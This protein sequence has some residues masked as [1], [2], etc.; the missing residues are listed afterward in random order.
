M[1]NQNIIF[2]SVGVAEMTETEAPIPAAGEV[3]VRSVRDTISTGTERA[4]LMGDPNVSIYSN[5][6]V[7]IYPRSAGYSIAGV[8][9]AVGADVKSVKEFTYVY[10]R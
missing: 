9:E 6:K 2:T 8:V 4:N 3:L 10:V 5:N 1:K 7:A